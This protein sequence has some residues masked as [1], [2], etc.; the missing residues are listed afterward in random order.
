MG[1]VKK[2]WNFYVT[3][4]F[5]RDYWATITKLEEGHKVILEAEP[6]NVHDSN[7]IKVCSVEGDIFGYV[8]REKTVIA[9]KLYELDP[10]T[11]AV[12]T[13][14]FKDDGQWHVNITTTSYIPAERLYDDG[15]L[16]INDKK[17][18]EQSQKYKKR[19]KINKIILIAFAVLMLLMWI[20]SL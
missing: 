15:T 20:A 18:E 10:Q 19:K 16:E 5:N 1:K 17:F 4:G 8:P 6:N 2:E 14:R 11:S 13:H 3:G 7:A 12:V 9:A